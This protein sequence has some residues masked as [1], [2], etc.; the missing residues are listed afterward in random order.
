MEPD[1]ILWKDNGRRLKESTDPIFMRNTWA[2]DE[3]QMSDL[4][5]CE[6]TISKMVDECK[7]RAALA[8]MRRYGTRPNPLAGLRTMS[9]SIH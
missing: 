8:P 4:P 6:I 1:Q 2:E 3:K 7:V 9:Q 5:C